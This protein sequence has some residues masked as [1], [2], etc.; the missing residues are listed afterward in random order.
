MAAFVWP[1]SLPQ[2]LQTDGFQI[3]LPKAVLRTEMEAGLAKQRRRFTSAPQPVTGSLML[4]GT[5]LTAFRDFYV[6]TLGHG[7]SA[8][9]WLDPISRAPVEM[10]FTNPPTIQNYGGDTYI[11]MLELEIMP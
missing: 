9:D 2:R 4:S 11:V 1:L 8:F 10:R 7:A 3:T 5:Q 6:N